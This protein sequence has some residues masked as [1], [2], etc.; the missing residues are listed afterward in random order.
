M[1][2]TQQVYI[3]ARDETRG[4]DAVAKIEMEIASIPNAG[5]IHWVSIDISTPVK[6]KA[7]AH[8]F[9]AMETRLDVLVNNAG[10]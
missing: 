3:G 8:A 5:S 6:A 9:L 1:P 2:I 7:S 10:L 4:R